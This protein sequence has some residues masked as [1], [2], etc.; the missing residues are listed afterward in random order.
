[1]KI[2]ITG[3]T[4]QIGHK[5]ALT[6]AERNNEIHILVRNPKSPNIPVHRNIRV[7]QGDITDVSSISNAIQNCHQV[8][9]TAALV[10]IFDS[11]ATQ[12]YKINVEGT[13]NLLEKSLEFGI[14]KF[15]F[16]SSCS[17]IGPSEGKSLTEN[18]SRTT[19]FICDYDSTKY[20]AENLVKKYASEGLH[21]VIVSP[22]KIYG[23]SCTETKSITMNT[24]IH[25]FLN[26]KLTFIP[27]PS[28][29]IANYCFIDDVIEGHIL[30]LNKG[31]S[32][33]NYILGGENISYKDFFN[34][35]KNVSGA[36]TKV[37]EIP[38]TLL[39][40]VSVMQWIRFYTT[41]K[42][43]FVTNKS[44]QQIF[45]NKLF[46]SNKAIQFLGYKITPFE[47]ALKQTIPHLKNQRHE[48]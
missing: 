2:L 41:Q 21:A 17:V 32:G 33:E 14:Q 36:K 13:K 24:V 48:Y 1:M 29:L 43:P 47:E 28:H 31:Q 30:A 3:A 15:L 42:E 11:D 7:F 10:K 22:S 40:I 18:H 6:L 35:V 25:N 39:K 20:E 23:Y 46:S 4:G 26:G 45:C 27:K 34:T 8:Y 44:I 16:T 5:L 38:K 37:I 19:P 9:H 12:F